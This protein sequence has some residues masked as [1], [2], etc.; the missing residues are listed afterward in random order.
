MCSRSFCV[1]KLLNLSSCH[2]LWTT[3]L[4]VGLTNIQN[5]SSYTIFLVRTRTHIVGNL[6]DNGVKNGK[7]GQ[8]EPSNR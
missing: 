1:L 2:Q 3:S 4:M 6:S 7:L 8:I 5:I